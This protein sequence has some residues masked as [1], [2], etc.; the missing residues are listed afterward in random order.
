MITSALHVRNVPLYLKYTKNHVDLVLP[1]HIDVLDFKIY[2]SKLSLMLIKMYIVPACELQNVTKAKL[3][4][5]VVIMLGLICAFILLG[6]RV[7]LS[8]HVESKEILIV[9]M[10]ILSKDY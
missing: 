2:S 5:S 1:K 10:S 7:S 8:M 9:A 6:L 3:G 4:P